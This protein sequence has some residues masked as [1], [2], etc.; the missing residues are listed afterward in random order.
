MLAP[1]YSLRVKNKFDLARDFTPKPVCS[2][3]TALTHNGKRS[4]VA[5]TT[6]ARKLV[7]FIWAEMVR[8]PY[9]SAQPVSVPGRERG[10]HGAQVAEAKR[11]GGVCPGQFRQARDS[12]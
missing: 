9:A 5:R 10:V 4:T 7:G 2:P 6:V 3:V 1:A 8:A 12:G 11:E